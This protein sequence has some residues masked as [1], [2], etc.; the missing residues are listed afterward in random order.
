[1]SGAIPACRIKI[2]AAGDWQIVPPAG[3]IT[4]IGNAGAT[5]QGLVNNDDLF[6]SG[7]L[8]VDARAY[9]DAGFYS[10]VQARL[11]GSALFWASAEFY[12]T[13]SFAGNMT[14]GWDFYLDHSGSAGSSLRSPT[15]VEELTIAVGTGA[16]GVN[17]A[18][19]LAPVNSIIT[20]VA[21]RVTQ[22]PGGGATVFDIGRTG[23]N[24]DEFIQNLAVALNT[25]GNSAANG[26]GVNAGPV[27][28]A[29]ANTLV[30]TT[31]ANVTITDMKV[32]IVTWYDQIIEPT[33]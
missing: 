29:A 8:E 15:Q 16:A 10:Y 3:Q 30:V 27:H 23:G 31:D 32:R 17:T 33:S 5:S 24:T 7:K 28:N 14:L 25:T 26:D 9:F 6:V 1:M 4:Q 20:A 19:N 21:V 12:S 22:A 18:A 11:Y 2:N 13:A